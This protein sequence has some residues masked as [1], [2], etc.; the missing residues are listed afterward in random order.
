VADD[1]PGIEA[2]HRERI[3]ERFYRVDKGR[4]R[5]MGG[6]GLGLS[7]AK[8]LSESMGGLIGCQANEPRGSLFWLDLPRSRV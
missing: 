1:G 4:S 6:S 3:F 5:E 8:N 7:I 2:R